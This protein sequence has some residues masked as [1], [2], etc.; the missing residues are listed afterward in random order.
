MRFGEL[1]NRCRANKIML[2]QNL[3]LGGCRVVPDSGL[4][5]NRTSVSILPDMCLPLNHVALCPVWSFCG[6]DWHSFEILLRHHTS[7]VSFFK[8]LIRDVRTLQFY[9]TYFLMTD[10]EMYILYCS[11]RTTSLIYNKS[12]NT[13]VLQL[14]F[15]L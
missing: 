13:V 11:I 8:F 14:L 10:C 9:Y 5:S 6:I 15:T 2:A 1:V 7:F 3:I 4:S 12:H